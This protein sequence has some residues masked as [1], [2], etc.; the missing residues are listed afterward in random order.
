MTVALPASA[1]E[2]RPER[3]AAVFRCSDLSRVYGTGHRTVVAVHTTNCTVWPGDRIALVGPSG[4][5]KSTLLHLMAG[6][7][8]PTGGQLSWPALG[9]DPAQHRELVGVVF[10]AP[11]LLDPLDAV[12][13][14]ELPLLLHGF[15]RV[16]ARHR[17]E[18]AL[19]ELGL[20]EL[21][22]RLPEEMSGGQ[23]QRVAAARVLAGRPRLILA[24]EPTGQL[25]HEI[26]EGVIAG[27]LQTAHRLGAAVVVA[28]HDPSVA[29]QLDQVWTMND[30]EL[31]TS[32]QVLRP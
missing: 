30:G 5:G 26:A 9:G 29:N 17:A 23:A 14:V 10:Q 13:N 21:T 32:E 7:E 31:I 19:A 16:E 28:T 6:L 11:S 25:D 8:Q 22:H 27:L 24:D 4:S 18:A 12:E 2:N 15:G 20:Q 1:G 3:T